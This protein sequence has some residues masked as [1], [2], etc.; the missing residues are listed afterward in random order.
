[1]QSKGSAPNVSSTLPGQD[2]I[3]LMRP[4]SRYDSRAL[5]TNKE[6]ERGRPRMEFRFANKIF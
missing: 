6:T 1:M 4:D 2:S 3:P 5:A